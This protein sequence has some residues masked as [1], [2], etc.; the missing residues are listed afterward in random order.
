MKTLSVG[1]NRVV[2]C[3]IILIPLI[4]AI[5]LLIGGVYKNNFIFVIC[6]CTNFFIAYIFNLFYIIK[7]DDKNIYVLNMMGEKKYIKNDFIEIKPIYPYINIYYIR[8]I[9]GKRYLFG[10]I[11]SRNILTENSNGFS[12]ELENILLK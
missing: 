7:Y 4:I 3:I 6:S 1:D 12:K 8:F 2:Y 9:D 5:V 10:V 11:S